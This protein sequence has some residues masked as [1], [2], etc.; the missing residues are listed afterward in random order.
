VVWRELCETF[1]EE[2]DLEL[3]IEVFFL[4]AINMLEMVD[5]SNE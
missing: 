5:T 2:V 4:Q 3:D 1:F